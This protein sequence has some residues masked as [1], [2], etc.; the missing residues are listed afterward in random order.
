MYITYY[1]L[2][3]QGAFSISQFIKLV[4]GFILFHGIIIVL[5]QIC[6]LIGIRYF[7]LINLQGFF[8]AINK[9]PVLTL[10]P[11]HSARILAVLCLAYWR[12]HE[13]ILDRKLTIKELFDPEHKWV[14]IAFGWTMLTMGSGTAFI[15]LGILSLYFVTRRTAAYVIP[16]MLALVFLGNALQLKQMQRAVSIVEAASTGDAD[17]VIE[18]DGS[19]A[20][21]VI[22]LLNLFTKTDLTKQETWVGRKSMEKV[23][24]SH[25]NKDASLYSQYGIVVFFWGIFLIYSC[26]IYR[27]LS[28]ETLI[29]YFLYGFVINNIYYVWGALLVMTVVRYFQEQKDKN[30]L[31]IEDE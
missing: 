10:E 16:L 9:L 6:V 8:I 7:P 22:P 4:R 3:I 12:C 24:R 25:I 14:T 15:A 1:G 29:F 5:Q 18:A 19:A 27:I 13:L 30:Q 28:V 20:I 2:I 11:S 23:A 17:E 31:I 21:R 26:M